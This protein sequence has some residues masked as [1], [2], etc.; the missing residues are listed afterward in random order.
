MRFTSQHGHGAHRARQCRRRAAQDDPAGPGPAHS[1]RTR[2]DD[3]LSLWV[4]TSAA[5]I[6]AA[7]VICGTAA[8]FAIV[9]CATEISG[10]VISVQSQPP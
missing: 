1:D 2:A 3:C 6:C 5:V 8:I 9:I 10:A 7:A 4:M